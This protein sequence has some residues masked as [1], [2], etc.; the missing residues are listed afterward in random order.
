[1]L[2]IPAPSLLVGLL[3]LVVLLCLPLVL[4][5]G[6]THYSWDEA[7]YYVPAVAQMRAH[8]PALD[9]TRDSLSATSPGY[10]YFLTGLSFLSGQSLVSLR[11]VNLAVSLSLLVL[12][13]ATWDKAVDGWMRLAAIAPL[14]FSNFYVKSSSN[15]VTDNATLLAVSTSLVLGLATSRNSSLRWSCA[16]AATAVFLRQNTIWLMVPLLLRV[17]VTRRYT[18]LAFL[19]LPAMVLGVLLAAWSGLVPP[20]WRTRHSGEIVFCALTYHLAIIALFAPFYY[21]A[22]RPNWRVAIRSPWAV[23]GAI[24]G[25]LLA[26][27]DPT[28]PSY[29]SGRWGGYLWELAARLPQAGGR[30]LLFLVLAPAGGCMLGLLTRELWQRAGREHTTIWFGAQLGFLVVGLANR[31]VY[32]RY[33]EPTQLVLLVLWLAMLLPG[34]GQPRRRQLFALAAGQLGLTLLTAHGRTFGLF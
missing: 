25:L 28:T 2:R 14:A 8:W 10:P 31:Q 32:H 21:T 11:L 30:S 16:T 29:E 6:E 33:F 22:I 3:S 19:L 1:M 27:A 5:R 23:A 20:A 12:L 15:V 18:G 9:L 4:H 34:T 17:I 26:L 7:N 13:W 24:A